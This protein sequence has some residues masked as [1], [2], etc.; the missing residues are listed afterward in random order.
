MKSILDFSSRRKGRKKIRPLYCHK[1]ANIYIRYTPSL[2]PKNRTKTPKIIRPT[3][4]K[5]PFKH[6]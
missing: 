3:P 5:L 6:P 2:I 4:L 1:V